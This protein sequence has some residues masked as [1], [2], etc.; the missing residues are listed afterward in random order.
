[1][2]RLGMGET[3]R[4]D[5]FPQITELW[6]VLV[7]NGGNSSLYINQETITKGYSFIESKLMYE[8][9]ISFKRRL[10]AWDFLSIKNCF[11]IFL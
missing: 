9:L 11:S 8:E 1:M 3:I 6:Y 5:Y 7:E 10:R 4:C 2:S